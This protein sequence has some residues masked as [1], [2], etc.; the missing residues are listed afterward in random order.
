LFVTPLALY[1]AEYAR[2]R[3]KHGAFQSTRAF[4]IGFGWTFVALFAIGA[5]MIFLWALWA[6]V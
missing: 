6:F 5:V 3:D 1:A 2:L 4:L